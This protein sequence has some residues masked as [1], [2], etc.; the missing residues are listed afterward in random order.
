M[1][2]TTLK[3]NILHSLKT[4]PNIFESIKKLNWI[5]TGKSNIQKLFRIKFNYPAPINNFELFVRNNRGS[6][7]FIFS[8]VFDEQCYYLP[9]IKNDSVEYLIDLGANI[10]LSVVFFSKIYPNAK[11]AYVEPIKCN[12][13][14]TEHNLKIN[15]IKAFGFN[16]AVLIKNEEISMSLGVNDYG[17]KVSEISFGKTI[18]TENN[19]I[20][21]GLTL[22]EIIRLL[23]FPRIDLLKV[24]IEGYEGVLFTEELEWLNVTNAIIMEIHENID[25]NKIEKTLLTYGFNYSEKVKGNYFFKKYND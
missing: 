12:Y 19:I 11:I 14:L 4:C 7:Y 5:Y 16:N 6:D 15:G 23:D 21:S 3:R 8:E 2:F 13:D 20:V 18:D 9:Q 17:H 1:N 10:G 25:I 22:N 24:D